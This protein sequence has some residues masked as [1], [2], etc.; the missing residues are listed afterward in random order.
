MDELVTHFVDG[1]DV[2]LTFSLDERRIEL[3]AYDEAMHGR[4]RLVFSRCV[5]VYIEYGEDEDVLDLNNLTEGVSELDTPR[6]GLRAFRIG[7]ADDSEMEIWC[8]E[9]AMSPL[10]VDVRSPDLGR[11]VDSGAD[12]GDRWNKND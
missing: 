12:L 10:S 11:S 6:P 5:R 3:T 2:Q 4:Y 1:S 9:F 7:F 8:R